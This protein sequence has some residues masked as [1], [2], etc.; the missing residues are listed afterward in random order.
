MAASNYKYRLT[1]PGTWVV[2]PSRQG[3]PHNQKH[4]AKD[5]D[6]TKNSR[7]HH[8]MLKNNNKKCLGYTKR[9]SGHCKA[10]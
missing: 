10:S 1:G 2:G 9:L 7:A 8:E 4:L 5:R 3:E 6:A